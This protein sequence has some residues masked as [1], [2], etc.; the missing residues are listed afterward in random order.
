MLSWLLQAIPSTPD[1][2]YN[3][4]STSQ[5]PTRNCENPICSSISFPI[6]RPSAALHIGPDSLVYPVWVFNSRH[7]PESTLLRDH[8]CLC[9]MLCSGSV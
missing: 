8:R 4:E 6:K 9:A 7:S 5:Q 1:S 2:T 3:T